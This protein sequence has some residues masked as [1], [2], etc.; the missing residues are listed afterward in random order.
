[1]LIYTQHNIE[2]D[3]FDEENELFKST[4]NLRFLFF[5]SSISFKLYRNI[6]QPSFY[7]P[8]SLPFLSLNLST[9][10][11]INIYVNVLSKNHYLNIYRFHNIPH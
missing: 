9:V 1:M 10:N 11:F 4:V 6:N 3:V 5:F 7:L 2:I 8:P